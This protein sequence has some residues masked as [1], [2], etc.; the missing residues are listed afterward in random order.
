MVF[1]FAWHTCIR[2]CPNREHWDLNV[3]FDYGIHPGPA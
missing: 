1:L 2:Y 3:T